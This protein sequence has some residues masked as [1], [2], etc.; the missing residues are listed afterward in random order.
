MADQPKTFSEFVS[1]VLS[2]LSPTAWLPSATVVLGTALLELSVDENDS[3]R[4]ALGS[5]TATPLGDLCPS[6]RAGHARRSDPASLLVHPDP[7]RRGLLGSAQS[8]REH[9]LSLHQ[10]EGTAAARP[11]TRP[12]LG[13]ESRHRGSGATPETVEWEVC[14]AKDIIGYQSIEGIDPRLPHPTDWSKREWDIAGLNWAREVPPEQLH[15]S[16]RSRERL[17]AEPQCFRHRYRQRSRQRPFAHHDRLRDP[18]RGA[19][20]TPLHATDAD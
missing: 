14:S 11:R 13:H 5:L 10:E 19:S 17:S 3:I 1:D 16:M 12:R 9:L 8:R 4:G 6:R 2:Q 15:G 7:L 20:R 18:R